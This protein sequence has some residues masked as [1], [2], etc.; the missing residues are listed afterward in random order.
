MSV[1]A[2]A[3]FSLGLINAREPVMLLL[4]H[5]GGV[6]AAPRRAVAAGAFQCELPLLLVL[7]MHVLPVHGLGKLLLSRRQ[8]TQALLLLL[9]AAAICFQMHP[10][11]RCVPAHRARCV[12]DTARGVKAV[13]GRK[14][15]AHTYCAHSPGASNNGAG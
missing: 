15:A 5:G 14:E 2:V 3:G 8:T 9:L 12:L 7:L 6:Q 10:P 1:T 4:G 11:C 13:F